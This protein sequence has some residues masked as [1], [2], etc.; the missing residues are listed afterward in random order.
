MIRSELNI[1]VESFNFHHFH[2]R[3][4]GAILEEV[5]NQNFHRFHIIPNDARKPSKTR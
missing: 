1:Y 5:T 2:L 4:P 3:A